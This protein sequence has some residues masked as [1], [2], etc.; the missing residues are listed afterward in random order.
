M[1]NA[2]LKSDTLARDRQSIVVDEVFPHTPEAIWKVLTTGALTLH[3]KFE[4][5]RVQARLPSIDTAQIQ[6]ETVASWLDTHVADA[7]VRGLLQMLVRVTSF[8]NDPER[9]S[10]GAAIEQLQLALRAS[11]LYL[12]GG[13]Q[14]IV[15]GLRRVAVHSGVHTLGTPEQ[16]V[17]PPE[18]N[19]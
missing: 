15:D 12:D 11:V 1:N 16:L 14:T 4:L 13:W 19:A 10:A 9:Q 2:A 3:G 8:T 7:G 5:A 6:H 17:T 18:S